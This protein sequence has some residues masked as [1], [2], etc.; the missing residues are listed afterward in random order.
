MTGM[1]RD[2]TIKEFLAIRVNSSGITKVRGCLEA[3][4]APM[5]S[6]RNMST[7]LF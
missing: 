3:I 2:S 1:I 7:T 5:H 4:V 6:T